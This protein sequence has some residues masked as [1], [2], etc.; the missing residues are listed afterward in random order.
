MSVIFGGISPDFIVHKGLNLF[1]GY[2][3]SDQGEL[4]VVDA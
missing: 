3:C 1:A 4:S 2:P